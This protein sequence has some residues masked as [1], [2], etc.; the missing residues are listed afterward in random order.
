MLRRLISPTNT[1]ARIYDREGVLLLDSRSLY[2]RGDVLRFDLPTPQA[3]RP[4]FFER[5]WLSIRKWLTR[6]DLPIYRNSARRTARAIPR[7]SR[8]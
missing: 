7:S 4:G 3:E 1:R 6:G 2:G 8:R 5:Q